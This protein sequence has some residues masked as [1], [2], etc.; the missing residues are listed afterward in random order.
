MPVNG[1]RPGAANPPLTLLAVP[2]LVI[3]CLL[4]IVMIG[5]RVF[6]VTPALK[7]FPEERSVVAQDYSS[8]SHA[9]PR[10]HADLMGRANCV[11]C[12]R[13]A[14]ASA[15]PRFPAHKDCTGCHLA[16]FTT[17][18]VPSSENPIC[19]ICHTKDGL[20]SSNPPLKSFSRLRSFNA[21]F[22][23]AQHLLGNASA[24]PREGCVAC[25][26][27]ARRGVAQSIPARLGAHQTCYQCHSPG[28][29]S[30][31][32]SSCG[33]CHKLAP[34]AP[35]S[36][37]SR[38]FALSFSHA[39]HGPRQRLNC[40]SCHTILGQGLPQ[41]RQISSI[42]AAQHFANPRAQSCMTCHNGR[43]AFGD[44]DFNDCRRC[45]KGQGFRM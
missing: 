17:A 32:L 8:F 35:T 23:H 25:H 16:Q 33:Y 38:A 1:R 7:T 43:R 18:N 42:L 2:L 4:A 6:A 27:P 36:T 14:D 29:Q 15:E 28:G 5:R 11:S 34:Y 3:L 12:H 26:A 31:N 9:S 13:R 19:T 40:E 21:M 30:G 44:T 22:D 20:N 10:E 37:S 39:T 41:G 24:R 45:H